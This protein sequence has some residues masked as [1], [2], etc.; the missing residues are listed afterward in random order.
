[1]RYTRSTCIWAACL[2][3]TPAWAGFGGGPLVLQVD[4]TH[5]PQRILH[6]QLSLAVTPGPLRLVYPKYIPGEHGPTGPIDQLA[7]L[8]IQGAGKTLPW[9]RDPEDMYA[10]TVDVPLG[11]TSLRLDYDFM[12]PIADGFSGGSSGTRN[13]AVLSWNWVVLYPQGTNQQQLMVKPSV[14]WPLGWTSASA[15]PPEAMTNGVTL[16]TLV[17]SPVLAGAMLRRWNLGAQEAMAVAADSKAALAVP[18][19]TVAAYRRLVSETRYLFGAKPYAHYL[20]L[21]TA[22]D[23][24]AHFGLEHQQSS[25]NR[26]AEMALVDDDLQRL[27][28]GLLP[29]EFVHAWN[30]KYRRPAGL[31]RPDLQAPID[32]SMLWVYEGLT[33][34]YGAVLTA[35][36]HL[37]T[38][39]D[40]RE[41]LAM[42]AASMANRSG[43]RWRPLVDTATAA[44]RLY[45]SPDSWRNWRRSVDFYP[46]GQLLWLEVDAMLRTRSK[47]K[48]S[49]D[50]FA[51]RFYAIA[52]DKRPVTVTPY[53]RQALLAALQATWPMDWD[54]YFKQRLES[55]ATDLP[56]QALQAAGWQLRYDDKPGP[57]WEI[58]SKKK[59]SETYY[60][61]GL[62]LGKDGTIEDVTWNGKGFTA[63]MAPGMKL[64]AVNHRTFSTK[65]LDQAI[66]AGEP[67]DLLIEDAGFQFS[68]TITKP[69]L[70]YPHLERIPKAKDLL[71]A[72]IKPRST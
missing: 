22:S 27:S 16:E 47:G 31:V 9:R 67:L 42:V 43:R 46:E 29:H 61:L 15:L 18:E 25:D 40:F 63:G 35:R 17:D 10:L 48:V 26:M 34:Y 37:Q 28:S 49:L 12:M 68:A 13:L 57:L 2:L 72:I 62:I 32:S 19:E 51:R 14:L 55:V 20:F 7:G 45:E 54:G 44:Q 52:G 36:S 11:T 39:D 58:A 69:A 60:D 8:V 38:P 70:R 65:L 24:V 59:E 66:K 23:H 6:A 30:G 33:M 64:L 1:M 53:D 3:S 56:Q 71:Q 41:D 4:A 50:D 21:V 5:A